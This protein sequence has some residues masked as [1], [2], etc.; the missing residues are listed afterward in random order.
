MVMGTAMYGRM[1]RVWCDMVWCGVYVG[2]RAVC[3]APYRAEAQGVGWDLQADAQMMDQGN[4]GEEEGREKER[5]KK[6][7]F[8]VWGGLQS[9]TVSAV[10]MRK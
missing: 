3:V 6:E 5:K 10:E 8:G 4:G 1:W 9:P 7:G 2:A